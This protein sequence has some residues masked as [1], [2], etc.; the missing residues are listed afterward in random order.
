MCYNVCFCFELIRS[1]LAHWVVIVSYTF[2]EPNPIIYDEV[3]SSAEDCL[4]SPEEMPPASIIV[5]GRIKPTGSQMCSLLKIDRCRHDRKILKRT[6][7]CVS[8][9]SSNTSWESCCLIM[10]KPVLCLQR[11]SD[12]FIFTCDT[13]LIL[14]I[15]IVVGHLLCHLDCI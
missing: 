7:H 9:L 2:S 8:I 1:S 11:T 5:H 13:S 4:R 12:W 10:L 6:Q 3:R 15:N 14:M